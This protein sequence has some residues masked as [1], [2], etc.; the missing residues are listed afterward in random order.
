LL[1]RRAVERVP[2]GRWEMPNWAF[3]GGVYFPIRRRSFSIAGPL[4][5]RRQGILN[6]VCIYANGRELAVNHMGLSKTPETQINHLILDLQLTPT[7]KEAISPASGRISPRPLSSLST[8]P[9]TFLPAPPH[10][11]PIKHGSQSTRRD[12]SRTLS[13]APRPT[14][15]PLRD[16]VGQKTGG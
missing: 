5:G 3:R 8:P 7:T 10:A 2:D 15:S 16:R 6:A 13:A 1:V 12:L 4:I 9:Q 11:G 14:T